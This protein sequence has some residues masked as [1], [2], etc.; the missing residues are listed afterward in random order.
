MDKGIKT[1][2]IIH[3]LLENLKYESSNFEGLISKKL[4]SYSLSQRDKN[5]V[6][7][8]V[9]NSMRYRCQVERI[10]KKY[11]LKKTTK[12][13]YIL[14]LSAITQIVFLN[15]KEYAVVN[16]TV[17]L[18]KLS[19]LSSSP[20]FI[21]AVLKKIANNKINLKKTSIL[22]SDLPK[23]FLNNVLDWSKTKKI[24]FVNEICM[25]PILHIVFKN[26]QMLNKFKIEKIK[27]SDNSVA[28]N[29]S[30]NISDLPCYDNGDWWIQDMATMLPIYL[31]KE[32]KNK[33]VLDMC[34][35]PGGKSFQILSLGNNLT[36]IEKSKKRAKILR[37]NLDRLKYN[38]KVIIEDCL[39]HNTKEKYDI[40]ILDAPCSS[41]GTIRRNPEIFFR[42]SPPNIKK[43]IILQKK[44]LNKSKALIKKN[45][46]IIYMVCSFLESETTLQ[47]KSFISNN[48]NFAI[49][50]FQS[51]DSSF[52]KLI[53]KNG[54][55]NT[56]PSTTKNI[57]HDGFFAAKIR[58]VK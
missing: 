50:K 5:L 44:L 35:A 45:G 55:I 18:S 13:Q 31:T 29:S 57:R 23:W 1:R 17:E 27:T 15:F 46:L 28:I 37:E 47:I 43:E 34:A 42:K 14:L 39:E 32:I 12:Q 19:N 21:N 25:E 16:S 4:N 40:I 11:V 33:Q 26:N 51:S 36:M 58:Y 9:L 38:H 10:I 41:I 6:T 22:F 7:T 20:G 54:F 52:K 56:I 2:L 3:K 48:N 8:V 30:G 53:D 24:K 49:E